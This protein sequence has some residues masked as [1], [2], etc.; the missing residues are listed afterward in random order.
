MTSDF[1]AE[2]LWKANLQKENKHE[3][4]VMIISIM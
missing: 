4:S 3:V 2:A 1:F